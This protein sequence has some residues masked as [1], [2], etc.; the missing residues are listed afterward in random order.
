MKKQFFP[1][2]KKNFGFGCMRLP[3]GV[4]VNKISSVFTNQR[5]IKGCFQ[6]IPWLKKKQMGSASV[7]LLFV[8]LCQNP[9]LAVTKSSYDIL[10]Q[11][12]EILKSE[13]QYD[14]IKQM[15]FERRMKCP[16]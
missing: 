15:R 3:M 6:N 2:V 7:H 8:Y 5:L 9:R 12:E 4:G 11:R 13:R 1:E 16:E 10:N 14:I